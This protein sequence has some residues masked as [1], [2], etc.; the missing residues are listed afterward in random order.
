MG[1]ISRMLV[2]FFLIAGLL[3]PMLCRAGGGWEGGGG[4]LGD[5]TNPWFI[6]NSSKDM[7]TPTVTYCLLPD[8][9]FGFDLRTLSNL[10]EKALNF[11]AMNLEQLRPP[12]IPGLMVAS[13]AYTLVAIPSKKSPATKI[14]I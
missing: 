12:K 14:Q 1:K 7:P 10:V 4:I 5:R 8:P 9:D 6:S 11:G 13:C 2:G 3:Q